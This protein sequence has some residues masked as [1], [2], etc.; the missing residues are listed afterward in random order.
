MFKNFLKFN[1][2]PTHSEY[3]HSHVS[4]KKKKKKKMPIV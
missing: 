1:F 2:L 4:K 3:N